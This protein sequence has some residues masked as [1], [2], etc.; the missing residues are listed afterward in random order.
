[1]S[2][3][4]KQPTVWFETQNDWDNWLAE[5][6]PESIGVWLKIAKKGKGVTS[7]TYAEAL[8]TAICYGW[9]DGQKQRFDDQFFLQ[10]FTPR[11]PRSLWSKI[12]REKVENLIAAGKMQP[13][14][15]AEIEA[16]KADGR[17]D[18]AYD[19]SGN[20][21]VPKELQAALD[22]NPTAKAFFETLNKTNRYSFCFRVQT[23]RNPETR[24]ARIEK[25]IA[26]LENGEKFHS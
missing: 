11:R 2:D 9:I 13:A 22:A 8:D 1:M 17:W 20:M 14:G 26:M 4:K 19:S 5:N 6:H 10:K 15:M 7:V 12:N 23:T 16:A 25:L 18:A 3:V 21:T 24:K